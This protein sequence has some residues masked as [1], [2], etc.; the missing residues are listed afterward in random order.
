[1]AMFCA[2]F[3]LLGGCT[4]SGSGYGGY[5]P[6]GGTTGVV[7]KDPDSIPDIAWQTTGQRQTLSRE[8]DQQQKDRP[9]L[10]TIVGAPPVEIKKTRV[11]L[12]LPLTG[13]NATLGQSMLKAAQMALFDVG[14]TGFE[15]VPKDTRSTPEGAA[16]AA[17]EALAEN[18]RLVLGPIFAEDVRAAK[19]VLNGGQTPMIAFTTDW[20]QAGNGTYIMGFLPFTQ[21]TRVAQYAQSKGYNS[22]AVYA[23]QTEYCDMV[24]STLQ[25]SGVTIA[26]TARYAPAQADLLSS[27]D[28]FIGPDKANP[29]FTALMLPVGG[30]SL[31][32]VVSVLRQQGVKN[33]QIKLLGTGLWDD[34]TLANN[35]SVHGGWFAAPDPALRRDF[36]KRYQDNYGAT[37]PRL[38]SLAYDATAMAAVLARNVKDDPYAARVLSNPRGFAGIDGVFRFR[39]D[40]LSERGLAILEMRSSGARVIDPAP[41]AFISP[42]M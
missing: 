37:A 9:S 32:S 30:E 35:P 36:E 18:T 19:A 1:M 6:W 4:G 16:S 33:E 14:S 7:T 31:R 40:G 12:L 23:P 38:T 41:T 13:K 21:V 3:L 2:G 25:R 42:G 11:A 39:P 26:R 15:L 20:Q 27:V 22:I 24:I 10:Q 34:E 5:I 8:S 17:R 29:G 28:A